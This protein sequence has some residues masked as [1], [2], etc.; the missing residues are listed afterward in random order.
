MNRLHKNFNYRSKS[1]I[2]I[3]RSRQ[4]LQNETQL[5]PDDSKPILQSTSNQEKIHRPKKSLSFHSFQSKISQNPPDD[6]IN[7]PNE[8]FN[9]NILVGKA[10][11]DKYQFYSLQRPRLIIYQDDLNEHEMDPQTMKPKDNL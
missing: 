1:N 7:G 2:P 4:F 10:N 11:N 8:P 5:K 6:M 9:N 3:V